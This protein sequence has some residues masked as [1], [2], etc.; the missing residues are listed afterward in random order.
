MRFTLGHGRVFDVTEL[1]WLTKIWAV[2]VLVIRSPSSAF[3][4]EQ[5]T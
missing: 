5:Q 1:V 3:V 4:I 2:Q